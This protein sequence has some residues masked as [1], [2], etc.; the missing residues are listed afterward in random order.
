MRSRH[1]GDCFHIAIA[2]HETKFD[3]V[4]CSDVITSDRLSLNAGED[5]PLRLVV[6]GRSQN[7]QVVSEGVV[8]SSFPVLVLKEEAGAL[9][10]LRHRTARA[11]TACAEVVRRVQTDIVKLVNVTNLV[12]RR[13]THVLA[14]GDVALHVHSDRIIAVHATLLAQRVQRPLLGLGAHELIHLVTHRANS[15]S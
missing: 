1:G 6:K 11:F 2:F 14:G 10:E 9:A 15:H 3:H 12:I 7:G 4:N 5:Q 8:A 13:C